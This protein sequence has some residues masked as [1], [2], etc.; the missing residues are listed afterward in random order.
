MCM[1]VPVMFQLYITVRV[2]Y[3]LCEFWLFVRLELRN[4][5]SSH[6]IYKWHCN[7]GGERPRKEANIVAVFSIMICYVH[8]R[9]DSLLKSS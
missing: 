3:R 4:S 9:R 2:F 5:S 1:S 6:N 7:I 8:T